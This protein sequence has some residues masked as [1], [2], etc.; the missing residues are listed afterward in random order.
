MKDYEVSG[1]SALLK[2]Q[3][4]NIN[5]RFVVFITRILCQWLRVGYLNPHHYLTV[6]TLPY[7]GPKIDI[8][9]EKYLVS[10]IKITS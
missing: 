6:V 7:F 3:K 10:N 9:P 1:S 2:L 8:D 5:D 4:S